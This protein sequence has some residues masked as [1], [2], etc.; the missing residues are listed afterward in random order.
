M[1]LPSKDQIEY[2]LQSG[3]VIGR[4]IP[5]ALF[6]IGERGILCARLATDDGGDLTDSSDF[7]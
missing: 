4:R 2:L 6:R 7:S 1:P 3:V 5:A